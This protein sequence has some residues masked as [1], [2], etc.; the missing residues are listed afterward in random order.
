MAPLASVLG[1]S[2][3]LLLVLMAAAS[4]SLLPYPFQLDRPGQQACN[5]TRFE[6]GPE[7]REEAVALA[8]RS[9]VRGVREAIGPATP[10]S[11]RFYAL[12]RW[13]GS[14]D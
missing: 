6:P 10:P 8:R 13:C 3:V 2:W 12:E 11:Q 4:Q 5:M 1:A 7:Q 14:N 9:D